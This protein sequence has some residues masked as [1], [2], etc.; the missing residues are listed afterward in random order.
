MP[1]LH[2]SRRFADISDFP[3]QKSSKTSDT[4]MDTVQM[5]VH[6][7][8]YACGG[9]SSR[10]HYDPSI[11]AGRTGDGSSSSLMAPSVKPERA[12]TESQRDVRRYDKTVGQPQ[13]LQS[14]SSP[15]LSVHHNRHTE[16]FKCHTKTVGLCGITSQ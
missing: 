1:E 14:Q 2:P 9:T 5:E 11:A 3:R 6:L 16:S 4:M 8:V 13:P 15:M 10:Y 7:H 12:G